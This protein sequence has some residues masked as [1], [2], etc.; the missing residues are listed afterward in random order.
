MVR[1]FN[2]KP[3]HPQTMPMPLS[4]WGD[5][6]ST[7]TVSACQRLSI[8]I[9][10]HWIQSTRKSCTS[11]LANY[12]PYRARKNVLVRLGRQLASTCVPSACQRLSIIRKHQQEENHENYVVSTYTACQ[13]IING[14]GLISPLQFVLRLDVRRGRAVHAAAAQEEAQAA[15]LKVPCEFRD[16]S[17]HESNAST[18][19]STSTYGTVRS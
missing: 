12:L 10:S 7:E 19:L 11:I 5:K 6:L 1:T 3:T 9:K 14:K 15:A 8:I 17:F 2:R 18:L 13:L 4:D 16:Q